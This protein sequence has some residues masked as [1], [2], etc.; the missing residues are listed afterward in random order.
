MTVN[1]AYLRIQWVGSPPTKGIVQKA[2]IDHL[3]RMA[4]IGEAEVARMAAPAAPKDL[5]L[6]EYRVSAK[7][8][9]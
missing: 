5:Y 8:K 7:V 2:D 3:I 9:P 6:P 4:L 1:E